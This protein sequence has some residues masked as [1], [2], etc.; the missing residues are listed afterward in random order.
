ML[1]YKWNYARIQGDAPRGC[2]YACPWTPLHHIQTNSVGSRTLRNFDQTDMLFRKWIE[3]LERWLEKWC[4]SIGLW[5]GAGVW[6]DWSIRND[7]CK[8]LL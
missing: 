7:A 4:A 2:F 8:V 1:L 5:G 3:V 6:K